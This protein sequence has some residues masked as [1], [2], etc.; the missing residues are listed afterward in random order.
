MAKENNGAKMMLMAR[1]NKS[2]IMEWRTLIPVLLGIMFGLGDGVANAEGRL[3][4]NSVSLYVRMVLFAALFVVAFNACRLFLDHRRE[5]RAAAL[6]LD[7]DSD[8]NALIDYRWSW[9][10]LMKLWAIILVCWLPYVVTLFPGVYWSDTSKQLLEHYGVEPFTDH[11]P[12]V[13]TYLFGWLADLGQALFHNPILGLYILI[14]IQLLTA[15]ALLGGIVLYTRRLGLSRLACHV[16]LALFAL[17]PVFPV[18]FTSLAKDTLSVLFF[19][20]FCLLFI[21]IVRSKGAFCSR[22]W[23]VPTLLVMSLLTCVT[24]KPCVYIVVPALIMVCVMQLTKKARAFMAASA[25]IVAVIMMV[26]MPKVV[27][28][29]LGVQPG[30]KQ[31]TIPFA[32]QMVAHDVKY[33]PE[34]MSEADKKLVSDFLTIPY[35]QIAE[36]YDPVIADPVKGTSLKNPDLMGDFINLWLRKTVEHP[37]GHFEAW[38]GLVQGWFSFR[39]TDGSPSYMVVCTESAWYYDPITEL[40][41][42]WPK[43]AVASGTARAIYDAE[44]SIPVLNVLFFRAWWA[45]IVPFFLLYL[46]MRPGKGKFRRLVAMMPVN[47]SFAYLLLTPVSGM[48]GE[49]TRYLLQLMCVLPLFLAAALAEQRSQKQGVT[50]ML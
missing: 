13:L 43:T 45:S 10:S 50:G 3:P 19:I 48:G 5:A 30:G 41:P 25:L 16:Q 20:P 26:I 1:V 18:M 31:E 8:E 49:P 7:A 24:K 23:V 11:H 34:G 35:D 40:V 42:Q 38:L 15:P 9:R 6:A 29:A 47:M 21:E 46:A 36:V 32:I 28:P 2:G 4:L 17:F 44:Q 37:A 27:M 14:V 12:F 22:P 39:N 33:D